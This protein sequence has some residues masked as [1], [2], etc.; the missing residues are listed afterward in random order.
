[1]DITDIVSKSDEKGRPGTPI[2]WAHQRSVAQC[3]PVGAM[4]SKPGT[5]ETASV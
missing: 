4:I 3:G 5:A 2:P 1:M